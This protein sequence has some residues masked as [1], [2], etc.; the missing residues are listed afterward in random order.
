MQTYSV[1]T[2][3]RTVARPIVKLINVSETSYVKKLD[4]RIFAVDTL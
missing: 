1:D 4:L 3:I 2:Q